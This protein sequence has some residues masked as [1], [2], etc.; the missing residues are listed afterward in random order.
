[1]LTDDVERLRQ[2]YQDLGFFAAEVRPRTNVD[3]ENLVVDCVFESGKGD[4]F[5]ID[6]IEVAGN[7]NTRDDV[8]R[9]ELSLVEGE[10][11]SAA[12]LNRSK[13]RVRRLGFFEEVN[14]EARRGEGRK[15]D[16][17]ID[18]VERPTGSFSFGAGASG[19][20]GFI[21]NGSL[22]QDNLFGRGL[23]LNAVA[24]LGSVNQRATVSFTNPFFMGTPASLSFGAGYR[25]IQFREENDFDQNTWQFNVGSSYPLDE[26]ETRV[27]TNYNFSN[28]KIDSF[29]RV[30][31][32]LLQ[33]EDF[34]NSTTTSSVGLSWTR[35]TR[36]DV[37]F[38]RAGQL[39]N[40][41]AEFAGLGGLS[42]F[43]RFEAGSTRYIP[44]KKWV[45]FNS[46]FVFNTRAGYVMPFNSIGD[47]GLPNCDAGCRGEIAGANSSPSAVAALSDL[48]S[49]LEVPLSER[50]FVGGVG[51]QFQLRGYKSASVGPRR[52]KLTPMRF[53]NGQTV[54]RSVNRNPKRGEPRCARESAIRNRDD[55]GGTGAELT[56]KDFLPDSECDDVDEKDHFNNLDLTEVIGGN[57]AFV[58]NFEMQVP[59]SE[60]YGV[61]GIAFLDT[62][63]SFSEDQS[64]LADLRYSA[65]VGGRWLSPFGP[66]V[67][68][69]GFP[70]NPLADE[71]GSVFEFSFGGGSF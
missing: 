37:Q 12:A 4:L 24:D 62:G 71:K 11:Y 21:L 31:N 56:Q 64:F 41:S 66:I 20:D 17:A 40:L 45:G 70:L 19:T 10:L 49:D 15:V 13:A 54:F 3:P 2:Y 59:I 38:T 26:G 1:M 48:D 29:D 27:G 28:R 22:R 52:A 58:A 7:M 8:V 46:T 61:T 16:V 51:G 55:A 33:R 43:L 63:N 69:L 47:F 32:V 6:K 18:V 67:V 14:V 34:L 53:A 68:Y 60:D 57:K 44:L 9:R 39:T 35:D 25:S 23:S 65:G 30:A 36:D 42:N 50:Y 5:F